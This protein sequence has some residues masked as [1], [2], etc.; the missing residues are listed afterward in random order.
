MLSEAETNTVFGEAAMLASK[1]SQLAKKT[2]NFESTAFTVFQRVIL[3]EGHGLLVL[4]GGSP[5][6]PVKAN[7]GYFLEMVETFAKGALPAKLYVSEYLWELL[8]QLESGH[9]QYVRVIE[10]CSVFLP[11]NK[12]YETPLA[13]AV[14]MALA[15]AV[16]RRGLN[17]GRKIVILCDDIQEFMRYNQAANQKF[18]VELARSFDSQTTVTFL[19]ASQLT[20]DAKANLGSARALPLGWD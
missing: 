12:I 13:V 1:I 7:K 2:M 16:Y 20:W 3:G 14:P 6:N 9:Y 8:G 5:D 11:H 15:G 17:S 10:D 4:W 19:G 18:L